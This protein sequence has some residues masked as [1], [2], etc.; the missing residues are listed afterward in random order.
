M[1]DVSFEVGLK[2]MLRKGATFCDKCWTQLTNHFDDHKLMHDAAVS[3][4]KSPALQVQQLRSLSYTYKVEKREPAQPK[5]GR[6]PVPIP[7]VQLP[8]TGIFEDSKFT[9]LCE[10]L[11][12]S[13]GSIG[14]MQSQNLNSHI[15]ADKTCE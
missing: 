11:E 12:K 9:K 3:R 15:L 5:E 4:Q 1:Y 14:H 2:K 7:P 10:L 6:L 13:M 8:Q